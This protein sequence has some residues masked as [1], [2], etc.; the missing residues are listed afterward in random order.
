ME[1]ACFIFYT[2]LSTYDQFDDRSL[3]HSIS[4]KGIDLMEN[5]LLSSKIFIPSI[6]FFRPFDYKKLI[7]RIGTAFGAGLEIG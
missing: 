5:I 2:P 7:Y 6:I 3:S 4:I 1:K